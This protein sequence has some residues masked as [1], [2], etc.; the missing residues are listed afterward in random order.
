MGPLYISHNLPCFPRNVC[1]G[2]SHDTGKNQPNGASMINPTQ[3][4]EPWHLASA[5]TKREEMALRILVAIVEYPEAPIG[6]DWSV[7]GAVAMAD[8]LIA[9]LNGE[10]K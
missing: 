1:Y 6:N 3:K 10:T 8:D 5:M 7:L 2:S 9:T 4:T